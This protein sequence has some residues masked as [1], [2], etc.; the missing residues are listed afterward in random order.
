[1][2]FA[3]RSCNRQ[4]FYAEESR[5]QDELPG[6]SCPLQID[7]LMASTGQRAVSPTLV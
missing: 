7:C 2:G 5:I 6:Y 1:M 4:Q 3:R